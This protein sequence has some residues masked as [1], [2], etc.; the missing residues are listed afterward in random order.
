MNEVR[1]G[2]APAGR[3]RH[4]RRHGTSVPWPALCLGPYVPDGAPTWSGAA[5]QPGSRMIRRAIAAVP[6]PGL[7][8]GVLA[9]CTALVVATAFAVSQNVAGH[10]AD[11]AIHEASRTTASLIDGSV[12]PVVG[13]PRRAKPE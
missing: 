1:R 2:C 3:A 6:R 5:S 9:A 10:V 8:A 4:G 12:A 11:T 13:R 7:R